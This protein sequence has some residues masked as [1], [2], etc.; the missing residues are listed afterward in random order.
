MSPRRPVR[1][2]SRAAT[3]GAVLVMAI[4]VVMFFQGGGLGP[5]GG[6]EEH[7]PDDFEATGDP[8]DAVLWSPETPREETA[9]STSSTAGL[10]DDEKQA[11]SGDTLVVLIDE[12]HYLMQTSPEPDPQYRPVEL[13]RIIELA[14]LVPG[15]SNG[16][17]VRIEKRVTAR[18][19][20]EYQLRLELEQS[21]IGRDALFESSDLVP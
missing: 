3:G 16:I 17:R 15:D 1:K 8:G 9:D 18:A 11:L 10:T 19:S 2:I 6:S 21:G 20:A 4:L 13:N 14:R 12:H 5:G 7:S